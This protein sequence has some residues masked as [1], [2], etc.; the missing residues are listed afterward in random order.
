MVSQGLGCTEIHPAVVH[1]MWKHGLLG[2]VMTRV[3]MRGVTHKQHAVS[4][5][6][7]TVGWR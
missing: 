6:K 7:Q 3:Q 4:A 2:E 5:Y 1:I